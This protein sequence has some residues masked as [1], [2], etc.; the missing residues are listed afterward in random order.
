[1]LLELGVVDLKLEKH[2]GA[3]VFD[4]GRL[5]LLRKAYEITSSFFIILLRALNMLSLEKF[6]LFNK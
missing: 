4:V 5:G 1:M 2:L 6:S 3:L